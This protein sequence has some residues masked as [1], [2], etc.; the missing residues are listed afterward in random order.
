MILDKKQYDMVS[1]LT[2]TDYNPKTILNSNGEEIVYL[3]PNDI[4]SMLDDLI[5]E[6][7]KRQEKI[8]DLE[9]DIQDNY[10]HISKAEQ[11]D[12][13]DCDFI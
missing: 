13:N 8:E 2:Y 3:E 6:L 1:D 10:K 12:I 9:Q 11:Y 5:Y 4:S 7:D